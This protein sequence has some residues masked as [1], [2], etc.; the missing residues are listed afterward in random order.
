MGRI[1]RLCSI[2]SAEEASGGSE[3]EETPEVAPMRDNPIVDGIGT[4][5]AGKGRI[6]TA[7]AGP[8]LS[9]DN[10]SFQYF[11]RRLLNIGALAAS[12]VAALAL[13]IAVAGF[14][15]ALFKNTHMI[16]EW[17]WV[18]TLV[19]LIGAGTIGLL[20]GW[21]LG[22]VE[23][24]RRITLLL[25][26]VFAVVAL[27]LFLGKVGSEISRLTLS[28]SM[29]IGGPLILIFRKITKR[30]LIQCGKW[31][32]PTVVYGAA[33]TARLT[34]R[35]LNDDKGLGLVP[36]GVFE[37]E[38]G[39]GDVSVEGVPVLGNLRDTT[40]LAPAA[41]LALNDI[42]RYA[43]IDLLE[44]PLAGYRRVVIIPDLLEAPSL[45]VRPRDIGGILGLEVSHNL[46]DPL[47]RFLKRASELT[48]VIGTA[49]LWIPV[50]S[51]AAVAIWLGD[52]HNPIFLQERVGIRDQVFRAFKFRTMVPNSQQ[53]L[54]E[55]LASDPAL[56]REW[57]SSFKLRKD[58]RITRLGAVMR[59]TS[60]DELPQL[61]NVLS[62][63]MS[64]VGPRPLPRYHY[65]QL[66]EQCRRLRERVRPGIT[67][68]W[69]V[70]GRSDT[71][72]AGMVKWDGY[73]V[74]NWSI[75]LDIVILVRTFRAVVHGS[76][77]Y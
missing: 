4:G 10:P 16:P 12:D 40:P 27:G 30:W 42:P 21:G 39:G 55:A 38:E 34:I 63:T 19:Y 35:A 37:N 62:G 20:P 64:L 46:L 61:L 44:G 9:T 41:I 73:Y 18:I 14:M 31:G 6:S 54:Q 69:Q 32:L 60:L 28:V 23:E 17:S 29:M 11:K 49:P 33:E 13:G 74:R 53:A 68:L 8:V 66:P 22:A 24:L 45:W 77:A 48:L 75:W 2:G 50:L 59:R 76:G 65:E 26:G 58:P 3:P 15:R 70:S 67:G 57:E 52:R 36:V 1:S 51:L 43:L 5:L 7:D 72:N 25:F 56:R 47:A 71:G